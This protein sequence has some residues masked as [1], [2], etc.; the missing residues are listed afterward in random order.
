M[1]SGVASRGSARTHHRKRYPARYCARTST[2]RPASTT[3]HAVP[4]RERLDG[5]CQ[6]ATLA[7]GVIPHLFDTTFAALYSELHHDIDEQIEQVLDLLTRE[8][9]ARAIL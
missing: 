7:C 8:F 5:R 9:L 3:L 6:V 1:V 4:R 2:A